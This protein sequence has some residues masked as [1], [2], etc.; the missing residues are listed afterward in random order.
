M[1]LNVS[2]TMGFENKEFLK[3]AAKSILTNGGA[4]SEKTSKIVDGTIFDV[5]PQLSV[6]KASSQISLNKSLDETLKY[7]KSHATKKAAKKYILGEIWNTLEA[8]KD[9]KYNGELLELKIDM[10]R[11][12][13]AA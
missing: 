13:F 7:L 12:I 6:I 9:T 2:T 10:S 3:N 4:F 5:N 8:S 1:G 11:N